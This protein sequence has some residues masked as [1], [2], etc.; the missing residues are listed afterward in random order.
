MR[1]RER[2]RKR[3]EPRV[4]VANNKGVHFFEGIFVSIIMVG[5][6]IVGC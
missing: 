6:K 4:G 1:W 5:G 2:K 3:E